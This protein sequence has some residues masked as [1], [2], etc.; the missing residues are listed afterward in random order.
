MDFVKWVAVIAH[1]QVRK[2]RRQRKQVGFQLN[3]MTFDL[4]AAE[5]VER[6]RH[7]FDYRRDALRRCLSKLAA[8]DRAL[9]RSVIRK[10]ADFKATSE[11]S[12]RPENT[13]Y[14]ALNR[15]RRVLFER[16]NRA[17]VSEGLV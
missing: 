1:N 15:I 14:K 4:L 13:V 2:F 17:L 6:T 16:I 8:A 9:V 12:G 10:I 5:A 11:R 3:E 7:S